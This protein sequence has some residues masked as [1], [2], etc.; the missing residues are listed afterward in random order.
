ML[1]QSLQPEIA[2]I[3]HEELRGERRVAAAVARVERVDRRNPLDR[4]QTILAAAGHVLPTAS[5]TARSLR[6]SVAGA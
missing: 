6:A 1:H 5:A 2:R 4:L 3:R